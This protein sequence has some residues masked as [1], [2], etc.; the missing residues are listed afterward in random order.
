MKK[1]IKILPDI[2]A[3]KNTL[4]NG[5]LRYIGIC[6]ASDVD[7]D[8]LMT[9]ACYSEIFGIHKK[10]AN[11]SDKRLSIVKITANLYIVPTEESL[12]QVLI[13]VLLPY[14]QIPSCYYM[15]AKGINHKMWKYQRVVLFLF[16]GIIQISLF[17]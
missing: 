3:Q 2:T 12:L 13:A 7:G 1:V 9:N 14:L 6:Q 5:V 11:N 17:A 16:I 8:V 10:S 15:T 4:S